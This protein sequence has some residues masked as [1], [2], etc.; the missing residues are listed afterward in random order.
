LWEVQSVER[1][2]PVSLLTATRD[3]W[4]ATARIEGPPP[5]QVGEAVRLEFALV[6]AHLFDAATGEALS[7]GRATQ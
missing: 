1:L 2:G 5:A 6:Q 4:T 7:H 3:G